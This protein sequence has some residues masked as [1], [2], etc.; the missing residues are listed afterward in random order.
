MKI[1]ILYFRE[2]GNAEKMASIVCD[3]IF[4]T[5]KDIEVWNIT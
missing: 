5:D 4:E 1:T 3:G 2:T